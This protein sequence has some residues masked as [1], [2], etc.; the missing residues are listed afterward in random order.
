M[1]KNNSYKRKMTLSLKE[2]G[3][4][5]KF[6]SK[7]Y[8]VSV[9]NS[10]MWRSELGNKL[11]KSNFN[12][13]DKKEKSKE[14]VEE[15][16]FSMIWYYDGNDKQYMISLRS[17]DEKADVSQIAKHFGGGGHRNASGFT[18]KEASLETLFDKE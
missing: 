1:L 8:N 5:N 12:N 3:E 7:T 6:I 14:K 10:S 2:A 15:C 13:N 4:D 18:W 11:M 16:D 17:I 9:M